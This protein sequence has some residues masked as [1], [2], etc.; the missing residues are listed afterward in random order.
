MGGLYYKA[1]RADV[2]VGSKSGTTITTEEL[3]TTYHADVQ[4][5]FETGGFSRAEFA[6]QYTMGSA[7]TSNSI[8]M[9]LEQSPDGTN[10]FRLPNDSTSGGTS[11][12]TRREFTY[13]GENATDSFITIGIDIAYKNMR[14][15]FKETGVAA[16][17]GGVYCEVLLSGL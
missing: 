16:N 17:K 12:I 13:V 9:K 2:L 8:E 6:I 1:Q 15:N 7:E 5:A 14:V 3:E 10:W 11:T 4:K